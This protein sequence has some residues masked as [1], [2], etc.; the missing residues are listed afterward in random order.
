MSC[1]DPQGVR[2]VS[3]TLAKITPGESFQSGSRTRFHVTHIV[4]A[5]I[6]VEL[7]EQLLFR[8]IAADAVFGQRRAA[9]ANGLA[10]KCE[11]RLASR[12]DIGK[13]SRNDVGMHVPVGDVPPDR[14]VEPAIAPAPARKPPAASRTDRTARSCRPRSSRCAHRHRACAQTDTPIDRGRHRFAKLQQLRRLRTIARQRDDRALGDSVFRKQARKSEQAACRARAD[15]R[16]CRSLRMPRSRV[17]SGGRSSV[18]SSGH[19][20]VRRQADAVAAHRRHPRAAT[21]SDRASMCSMA[22]TSM[23][24][25][26]RSC[27]RGPRRLT[28]PANERERR[29]SVGRT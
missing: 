3:D 7:P 19:R 9:E 2:W 5:G 13:R 11:N 18:T 20:R 25:A 12:F 22:E 4:D 6:A 15:R 14:R 1:S 27:P 24:A 17:M 16:C 28:K 29:R 10:P 8:R 26:S 21:A 23:P